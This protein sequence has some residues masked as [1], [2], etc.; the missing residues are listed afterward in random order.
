MQNYIMHLELVFPLRVS[1][2]VRSIK[3]ET[4]NGPSKIIT[5]DATVLNSKW[6]SD[7]IFDS[8]YSVLNLHT[9]KIDYVYD[10][11]HFEKHACICFPN[12]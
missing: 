1:L 4:G 2:Q 10:L 9:L 5:F 11:Q 6:W 8:S 3:T 12:W 7:V